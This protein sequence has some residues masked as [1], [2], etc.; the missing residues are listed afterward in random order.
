[1][2][3][4]KDN[5]MKPRLVIQVLNTI[6]QS[7]EDLGSRKNIIN[8]IFTKDISPKDKTKNM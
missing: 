2:Y 7:N 5:K 8:L 6:I 1:M 3:F 4:S